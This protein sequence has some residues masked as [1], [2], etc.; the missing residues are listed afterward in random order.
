[1]AAEKGRFGDN[2]SRTRMSWIKPNFLWMMFRCGW[3]TKENQEV[4]LAIR[5]R[6]EGFDKILEEAVH[7][8]HVPEI[9]GSREQ[10]ENA[11]LQSNVRLQWDP[12]HHPGGAKLERRAIQLGLRGQTLER[13]ADEWIVGIENISEF[14]TEQ[15]DFAR[16]GG[17]GNLVMPREDVYPIQDKRVAEKLGMDAA[18]Q[19]SRLCAHG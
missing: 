1:L 9:Y 14:V 16:S 5:L 2:W 17:T 8:T 18:P 10:W 12:D 4:V 3:G 19:T 13:F 11:V 6:R 15:R 7:S